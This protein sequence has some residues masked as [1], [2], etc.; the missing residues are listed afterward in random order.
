[1]T[2]TPTTPEAS[3]ANYGL[4]SVLALC[5]NDRLSEVVRA[6]LDSEWLKD[7]DAVS[8]AAG[9]TQALEEAADFLALD[10]VVWHGDAGVNVAAEPW[11]LNTMKLTDWLR[12]RAAAIQTGER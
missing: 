1:M 12:A 2:E 11:S 3:D 6:I 9:R 10:G 5:R 4:L 8:F 7:R